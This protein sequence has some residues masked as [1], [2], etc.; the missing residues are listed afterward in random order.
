M[1]DT[2]HAVLRQ[3]QGVVWLGRTVGAWQVRAIAGGQWS[4]AFDSG[5]KHFHLNPGWA[6]GVSAG[7]N[8][9]AQHGAWPYVSGSGA[10]AV[11][12]MSGPGDQRLT[13]ADLR[14]GFDA[15]WLFADRFDVH[16]VGR[17]FGGP[18]FWRRAGT[19][20]TGTDRWHVQLGAGLGVRL[21]AG[22][23]VFAEAVPLGETGAS[24]GVAARW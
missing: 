7:R 5:G 17:L 15:G 14:I 19:T 8:I 20:D 18:V 4:G 13:A 24:A 3:Q 22:L 23:S 2:G 1:A 11:A 6:A 21:A 16:A 12:S 9:L 10:L